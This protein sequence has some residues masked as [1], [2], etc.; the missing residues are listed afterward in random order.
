MKYL[1]TL[2]PAI[3]ELVK[4]QG[5]SVVLMMAVSAWFAYD[6]YNYRMKME[7]QYNELQTEVRSCNDRIIEIYRE[8]RE[9]MLQT[10]DKNT[11]V[12]DRIEKRLQK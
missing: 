4:S 11:T 2:I 9:T 1:I 12:L 10:I 3:N 6:S 5:L 8:E 7:A